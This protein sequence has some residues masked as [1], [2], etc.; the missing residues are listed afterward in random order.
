[1]RHCVRVYQTQSDSSDIVGTPVEGNEYI[2]GS[3]KHR[4]ESI[5]VDELH[6]LQ[7]YEYL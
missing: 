7:H 4:N 1:M 3:C 5:G 2:I 6:L